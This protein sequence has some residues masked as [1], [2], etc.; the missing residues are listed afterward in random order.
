MSQQ[1]DV[2]NGTHVVVEGT[3]FP[4]NA[5]VTL[6][7]CNVES[8]AAPHGIINSK[9]CDM[10]HTQT[11]TSNAGG[12]VTFHQ[13]FIAEATSG[14]TD[15]QE[16]THS[17]YITETWGWSQTSPNNRP[18]VTSYPSE[19]WLRVQ[20][21]TVTAYNIPT[22]PAHA[23]YLVA[24]CTTPTFHSCNTKAK[25]T[26]KAGKVESATLPIVMGRV[27]AGNCGTSTST[28]VCYIVLANATTKAVLTSAAID[29]YRA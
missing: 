15:N 19:T 23:K 13:T 6:Y 17:K 11:A 12:I 20:K 16:V 22:T 4:A 14:L 9:T 21:V 1:E 7:E 3:D 10:T 24:E 18:F 29:F 27:G 2:K 25:T 26:I 8:L 28:E 5:P